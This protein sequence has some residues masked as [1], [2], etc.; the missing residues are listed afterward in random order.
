MSLGLTAALEFVRKR[1]AM[2]EAPTFDEIRKHLGLQSKSGVHRVMV[3][4][5]ER[6]HIRRLP[7]RPRAIELVEGVAEVKPKADAPRVVVVVDRNGLYKRTL[8]S[9]DVQVFKRVE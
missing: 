4:L 1:V 5:E 2:G 3:A 9:G 8:R 7:H 6:G